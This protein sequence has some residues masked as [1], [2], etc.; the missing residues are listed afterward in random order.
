M[1][2]SRLDAPVERILR[3][4]NHWWFL[5]SGG[6]ARLRAHHLTPE[7]TLTPEAER[8]LRDQGLF[9]VRPA[10]AYSLT[11]LTSTDCNLGC[12]YC[13]QN[14]AQDPTGGNRPPRIAH[15]RLTSATIG[16]ILDFAAGQMAREEL[17]Q[18][19]VM[20]FGG[21]PLLNPRGCVELL[22]RAADYGLISAS[23][24]SNLTLLTP[25]LAADL[26]GAGLRWVQVT[27]DG[28]RDDH[29]RIRVRRS[30]GGT[31]DTIVRNLARGAQ[32]APEVRWHLRVNFSHHN[33]R[34]INNLIDRLADALDTSR[35]FIYFSRVNDVN[36][37][38]GNELE[39]DADLAAEF[40]NWKFRALDLGFSITRPGP[41]LP[42]PACSYRDGR[43]GAVISADGT[44]SSC[45]ETAGK[46]GWQVGS[47]TDGYLPPEQTSDKWV[48]CADSWGY[49]DA[50]E[51]GVSAFRDQVDAA[52]LDR[53]SETGRL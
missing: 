46:P 33:Y 2:P 22:T 44:L 37:G 50:D 47:V 19:T 17:E 7:G 26:A 11:V 14:M 16:D 21:E 6:V 42:C 40:A 12:G 10:R 49:T 48:S 31:F 28:D 15:A 25:K 52:V 24:I 4:K 53:L 43:Y 45:W 32:A 23:M 39:H 20:L 5:G 18:L 34:G 8:Y 35:C 41:H 38:Y 51:E 1:N 9:H 36:V 29:D 27:F 30:N 3:G 13:F